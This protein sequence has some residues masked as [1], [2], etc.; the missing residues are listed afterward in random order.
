MTGLA[1]A[2][3]IFSFSLLVRGTRTGIACQFDPLW[4][5]LQGAQ[6]VRRS[7]VVASADLLPLDAIVIPEKRAPQLRAPKKSPSV[8]LGAAETANVLSLFPLSLPLH[9][10]V[11]RHLLVRCLQEFVQQAPASSAERFVRQLRRDGETA[12]AAAARRLCSS[13]L[14]CGLP[15]LCVTRCC[16]DC[17]VLCVRRGRREDAVSVVEDG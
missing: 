8:Q 2:I 6:A 17:G 9:P 15:R 11:L 12:P 7:G 5:T 13:C 4:M 16:A 10:H 1:V 3:F 14:R